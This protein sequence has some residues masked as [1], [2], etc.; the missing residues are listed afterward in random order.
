MKHKVL[1]FGIIFIFVFSSIG[2]MEIETQEEEKEIDAPVVEPVDGPMDSAWP[3]KCHDNRHTSQSPYSTEDNPHVEK[4]RFRSEDYLGG[5]IESGAIIDG[6]GIIYIGTGGADHKLYAICPDGTK[7]WSY[8]VGLAIWRG[9]PA[10]DEYGIIYV[11]SWDGFLH[12]VC[13]NG[14]L[15]WKF[16]LGGHSDSSPAIGD[17]G[18][19]YFGSTSGNVFAVNPN[20]T[21]KWSYQTGGWTMSNPAIDENEIIYIGS[22]DGYLYA[23]YPNGTLKWRFGTGYYIRSHPSIAEDGTIY[24]SS[25][26]DY[27]YAIY[28]NGSLKWKT[29]TNWGSSGSAAIA[30]DGT[31]YLFTDIF[32]AFYPN[33]GTVKWSLDIGGNGAL[34]SPAI[35][36]DGTI[37]TTNGDGKCIIA[38][39]PDGNEIWRKVLT[40]HNAH[41]SPCIAEDG[42]VYVC[43]TYHDEGG[44]NHGFLHAFG[45]ASLSVDAGGPYS[46][47]AEEAIQFTGTV[48][49]GILP[50]TYTWDFG[51]GN[52]SNEENPS[53]NYMSPGEYVAI[54]TVVDGE[55]NSSSDTAN[56]TVGTARPKVSILKP[57]N[58][59]YLFNIRVFPLSIPVIIGRITINVDASQEEVG[60]EKVMFFIDFELRYTDYDEPYEWTWDERVFFNHRIAVQAIS[61]DGKWSEDEIDPL[62]KFF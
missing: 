11:P 14:T 19:I 39:D 23:L 54:F 18:T 57:E 1:A 44:Y 12:A 41:T 38:I 37:Y 53:Y 61:N 58:G 62:L 21:E 22:E 9:S 30:S 24:V 59:L 6:T 2:S 25:W 46:G 27:L 28:Q 60:I 31:I 51:D 36:S 20:G 56:V 52:I 55:D 7:K 43:S 10:I 15:R 50:Y 13:P 45:K 42:T 40:N 33:N 35:S 5:L 8:E 32:R 49:G 34:I 4:W 16:N 17:D 48:F 26:D 47:N 3:M 29:H